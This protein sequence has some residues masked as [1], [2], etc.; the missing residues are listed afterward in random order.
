VSVIM[1]V[2]DGAATVADAV[3]SVQRQEQV[4]FELL[5]HDDGS[6]DETATVL[7]KLA[8]EDPRIEVATGSSNVPAA[9]TSPSSTTTMSGPTAGLPG[10]SSG[11][12]CRWRLRQCSV[13]R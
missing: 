2:F 3:A 4:E 1:P 5:V 8:A 9:R 10:N 6:T 13:R 12:M 7:E 11:S